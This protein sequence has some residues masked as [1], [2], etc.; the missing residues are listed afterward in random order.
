[1]DLLLLPQAEAQLRA[2]ID[3]VLSEELRQRVEAHLRDKKRGLHVTLWHVQRDSM[4]ALSQLRAGE[5]RYILRARYAMPAIS[6]R[7]RARRCALLTRPVVLAA[8]GR[9]VGIEL[10][11]VAADEVL[12]PPGSRC[13]VS[14]SVLTSGMRR[15]GVRGGERA[16]ATGR[17]WT[18]GR[19]RSLATRLCMVPSAD[20]RFAETRLH[21]TTSIPTLLSGVSPAAPSIQMN[22]WPRRLAE[23]A[24]AKQQ[25]L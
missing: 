10:C 2:S 1:V 21:V 22:C 5:R 9:R 16:R 15:S 3:G 23:G 12:Q 19:L 20:R 14:L 4:A 17:G 6:L 8:E 11:A 7:A 18:A 13:K 25:E 24:G